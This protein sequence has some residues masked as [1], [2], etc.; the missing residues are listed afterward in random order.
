MEKSVCEIVRDAESY[1]VDGDVKLGKYVNRQM[2]EVVSTIDAYL[3][4]T[5][6][7]GKYDSQNREKPF[8]NIV[9]AACNIWYRATDLDRKNIR[10]MPSGVGSV[11][12][13]YLADIQLQRWM[14]RND[15][16]KFLNDWGR[17]LAKYGSAIVKFIEQD[18]DLKHSV[19]SWSRFIPD[20]IDF[21]AIPK[22]EKFYKTP[23]QLRKMKEYDQK[24]VESLISA[25]TTRKDLGGQSK[26]NSDNFIEIYEV[27]GELSVATYKRAKGLEVSEGEEE[28]YK[29][30]MHVISFVEGEKESGDY[31][32]F[33]LFCGYEKEDPY[34]L[35][36][37]IEEDGQTLSIGAVESLFD[38]Q[39]MQN[40]TIYQ[41]KNQLDLASKIIFQTSDTNYL[42]R[43]VLSAI[44]NGDIMIHALNQPLTQINNSSHDAS[45]LQAFGNVWKI[46]TQE[47]TSTPDAM[48]G[49]TQ[50]SGTA[51]R[52]VAIQ[53][54]EAN[55]LFE[56]MTENKGLAL[57]KMLRRFVIP[58]LKKQ[59]DTDEEI[60]AA[61]DDAK[62]SEIDAM[63]I[64]NKAIKEFNKSVKEQ[65]L[66]NLPDGLPSPYP[67]MQP[68]MEENI[69][70]SLKSLGNKRGFKPTVMKDGKEVNVTWKEVF[71][72][73]EWDNIKV[74]ITN[75]NKDK[76][77]V[78][79]TLTSLFQSLAQTDPVKANMVLGKIM[80][81]TG[82]MS[83]MEFRTATPTV[84]NI[85][86]TEPNLPINK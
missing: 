19:I 61:L 77:A 26:D 11:G 25:V 66:N 50:P 18:G 36:H 51:Y 57:E 33:T 2:Y 16:G 62:L 15:F 72:D 79:A 17:V 40:H 75:E 34:M 29:Q 27:H 48:R 60:M 54:Q 28:N 4:S 58:H 32:D 56:V 86:T 23:A 71:S 53:Q 44:E 14:D 65:I 3:A 13:A 37:L 69:R 22:I 43:N 38:A 70:Q 10:F 31:E 21:E 42:G 9:T 30:Q 82:V 84:N 12:L 81:E 47:I 5:H 6:I 7:S 64:P 49:N 41:W 73:F 46:L 1:Y 85:Q 59:L 78:M 55:S 52:S 39:W 63:Y 8:F 80:S 24:M 74:E 67:V 35:T 76:Q 20:P 68:M 45:S 83:P